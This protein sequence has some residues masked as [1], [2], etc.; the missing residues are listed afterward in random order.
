MSDLVINRF[1]LGE[2]ICHVNSKQYYSPAVHED[3]ITISKMVLKDAEKR[4]HIE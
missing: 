4:L 1:R 2:L 3:S